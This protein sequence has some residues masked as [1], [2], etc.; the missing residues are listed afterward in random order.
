[1]RN[2]SRLHRN[3]RRLRRG[4]DQ[5]NALLI[6]ANNP[7]ESSERRGRWSDIRHEILRRNDV[8]ADIAP[9]DEIIRGLHAI[10]LAHYGIPSQAGRTISGWRR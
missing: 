4:F 1:M 7:E 6:L 10:R 2:Y 5:L 8:G 3:R 9:S